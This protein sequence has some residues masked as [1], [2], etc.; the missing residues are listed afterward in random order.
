MSLRNLGYFVFVG[1]MV[2]QPAQADRFAIDPHL[3]DRCLGIN[4]HTPMAC[5]GR[6]SDACIERNGGGPNMVVSVCQ[7]AEAEVWDGFL[8]NVY[9]ELLNLVR[10]EQDMDVGYTPD[11]LSDAVR[12]MQRAWIVY[13]DA[14]CRVDLARAAPFGSAAGPAINGCLMRETARQYFQLNDIGWGYR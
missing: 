1:L 2:A 14:T 8:N 10:A 4:D 9:A 3:I 7:E 12:D 6:Q 13:R 11:Q 5:V